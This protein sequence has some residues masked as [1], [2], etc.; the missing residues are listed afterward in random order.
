MSFIQTHTGVD[1]PLD[2]VCPEIISIVDIAQA[3]SQICRFTG[4]TKRFYSVAQHSVLAASIAPAGFELEALMHDAHEAYTGDVAQPLKMMLP[5]YRAIEDRIERAVRKE[6]GLPPQMSPDVKRVDM[7]MLAWERRDMLGDNGTPWPTLNGIDDVP[8]AR[9]SSW[10][11][12]FARQAFLDC[13]TRLGG[14]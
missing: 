14:K 2:Q 7:M 12:E 3:L 13:F 1:F 6:F 9:L 11:P 4:H 5:D 10:P 8:Q